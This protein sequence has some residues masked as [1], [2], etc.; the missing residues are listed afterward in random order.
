[1]SIFYRMYFGECAQELFNIVPPHSSSY[2][3]EEIPEH[4]I[5]SYFLMRTAKTYI[6][7][8]VLPK[9]TNKAYSGRFN[10]RHLFPPEKRTEKKE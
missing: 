8:S 7:V 2:G 6:T 9:R 4:P 1:M 10:I 3:K 5:A